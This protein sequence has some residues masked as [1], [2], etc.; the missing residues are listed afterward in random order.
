MIDI[1]DGLASEL[2]HLATRSKVGFIVEEKDPRASGRF[3]LRKSEQEKTFSI[4]FSAEEKITNYSPRSI[5]REF[6]YTAFRL[7]FLKSAV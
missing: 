7:V 4:G 6:S 1:S 2:H 3:V 5:G